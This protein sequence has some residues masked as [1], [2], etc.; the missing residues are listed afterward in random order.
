MSVQG[1]ASDVPAAAAVLEMG[2]VLVVLC[3][4]GQVLAVLRELG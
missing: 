3:E 1:P 4:L 2:Q